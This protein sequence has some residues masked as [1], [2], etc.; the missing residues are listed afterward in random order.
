M[1]FYDADAEIECVE[2]MTISE[3]FERYGEAYFRDL[4]RKAIAALAKRDNTVIS[5]GGGAVLDKRNI[6][7]LKKTSVIVFLD[8]DIDEITA[9]LDTSNRPLAKNKE[10]FLRLYDER[11]GLYKNFGD[12]TVKNAGSI[13]SVAKNIIEGVRDFENSD[14]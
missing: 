14:N 3:I 5:T 9:G 13:D 12:I 2:R 6:G 10:R 7:A 11:I 4:E 8:R 1:E